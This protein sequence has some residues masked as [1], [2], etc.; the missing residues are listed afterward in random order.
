MDKIILI[1]VIITMLLVIGLLVL[2][3]TIYKDVKNLRQGNCAGVPTF[4]SGSVYTKTM[5]IPV[6]N[7]TIN[8]TATFKADNTFILDFGGSDVYNNNKWIYNSDTCSLTVSV[9]PN[10]QKVL[11]QY[12]SSVNNN[13]QINKQGQLTV[14]ALIE[15]FIP[16]QITLDKQ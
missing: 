16:M 14:N 11:T 3:S 13:I 1:L 8:V 12:N 5:T 9:D 6:I 10:L 7:K 15:G 4:D 2:C